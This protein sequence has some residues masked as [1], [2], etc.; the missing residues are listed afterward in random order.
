MF[1]DPHASLDPRMRVGAIIGE[2]LAIQRPGG[3]PDDVDSP[4]GVAVPIGRDDNPVRIMQHET[5]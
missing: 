3:H 4:F 5:P 1:Q 2:P